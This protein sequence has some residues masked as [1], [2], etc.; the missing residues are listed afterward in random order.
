M[1]KQNASIPPKILL[2]TARLSFS[3]WEKGQ[4][5]F[6]EKAKA[7]YQKRIL[8]LQEE[9]E[10]VEATH[11][12]NRLATLQDEQD[13]IIE[14]LSNPL[15][16]VARRVRFPAPLKSTVPQS[17]AASAALSRKLLKPISL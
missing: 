5:L 15:V 4:E 11:N 7:A 1:K 9:F 17:P 13:R 14:H 6:D 10:E 3:K 8:A 12:Y 16:R 2:L